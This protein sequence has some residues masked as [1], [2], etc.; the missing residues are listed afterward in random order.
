MHIDMRS[1]LAAL[2][3]EQPKGHL[4]T[5]ANAA[6]HPSPLPVGPLSPPQPT[7][8][9]QRPEPESIVWLRA[10]IEGDKAAA[11]AAHGLRYDSAQDGHHP[12]PG[13]WKQENQYGE[14]WVVEADEYDQVAT[15]RLTSAD[16]CTP[17]DPAHVAHIV[18]HDPRDVAARCEANLKLLDLHKYGEYGECVT[19]DVGAQ[20]CGCCGW[21]DFPCD[22]IKTVMSG[23]RHREGFKPEW[24]NA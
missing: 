8:K 7:E 9:R 11:E 4:A 6:T 24:V 22:T 18:I 13:A 14:A 1:A 2:L 10:A 3:E 19:C 20:S 15:D 21:G 5:A 17:L 12:G 16:D 23:Y